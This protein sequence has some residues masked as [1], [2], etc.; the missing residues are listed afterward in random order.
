M[1]YRDIDPNLCM[2]GQLHI[3]DVEVT[4]DM[5]SPQTRF[6]Y[7][8][9]SG[10]CT[11]NSVHELADSLGL[12]DHD[13]ADA[14]R[15]VFALARSIMSRIEA[16]YPDSTTGLAGFID[17]GPYRTPLH[18]GFYD[19]SLT[20]SISA[21]MWDYI[22]QNPPLCLDY[23]HERK[24]QAPW[25]LTMEITKRSRDQTAT[26]S[27]L[28]DPYLLCSLFGDLCNDTDVILEWIR[29]GGD[30]ERVEFIPADRY[31]RLTI[32]DA[33][34][35]IHL[36]LDGFKDKL[37]DVFIGF[38]VDLSNPDRY[39][40]YIE[41]GIGFL[42]VHIHAMRLLMPRCRKELRRANFGY[43]LSRKPRLGF[44][45]EDAYVNA[46]AGA[47]LFVAENRNIEIDEYPDQVWSLLE[48]AHDLD[49]DGSF[50]EFVERVGEDFNLMIERFRESYNRKLWMT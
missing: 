38:L 5:G 4:V 22:V 50:E 26:S 32:K 19:Y 49:T 48:A 12:S 23:H 9:D 29:E 20:V 10:I 2:T 42:L 28:F 44:A 36:N 17:G 40:G 34:G 7:M 45:F 39:S 30:K 18:E 13:M 15:R 47:A 3:G 46:A 35:D 25:P 8:T 16:Q 31:N 27:L 37:I 41:V 14:K 21:D 43:R 6:G 11:V 24:L 1:Y 33:I